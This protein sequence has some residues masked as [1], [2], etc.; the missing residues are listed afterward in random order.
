MWIISQDGTR[1]NLSSM[2]AYT[3]KQLGD[4]LDSYSAIAV[5]LLRAGMQEASYDLS[6][7]QT[8]AE[9]EQTLKD[10][11]DA[12]LEGRNLL[13]LRPLKDRPLKKGS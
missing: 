8:L 7:G 4:S 1:Y 13:D 9:V 3:R 5:F 12:L 10:I 6:S 11:D 2:D